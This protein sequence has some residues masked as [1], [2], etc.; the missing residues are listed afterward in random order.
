MKRASL[1]FCFLFAIVTIFS[2][3]QRNQVILE[4]GT[5]RISDKSVAEPD[6]WGKPADRAREIEGEPVIGFA[7]A[8]TFPIIGGRE[9]DAAGERDVPVGLLIMNEIVG[10]E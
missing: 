2:Q 7:R 9:L 6:R 4:I 3:V 1:T 8:K 5:G 10:G